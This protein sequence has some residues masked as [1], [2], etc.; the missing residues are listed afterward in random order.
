MKCPSC[1]SNINDND[2]TCKN[3]GLMTPG[4]ELFVN[5]ASFSEWKEELELF[6]PAPVVNDTPNHRLQTGKPTQETIYNLY[7]IKHSRE[8]NTGII[9]GVEVSPEVGAEIIRMVQDGCKMSAIKQLKDSTGI[10]LKE[11]KEAVEAYM[12][13]YR[14]NNSDPN[15]KLGSYNNPIVLP[16]NNKQ[17]E[18]GYQWNISIDGLPVTVD[19][20]PG[21]A[22]FED[23][24][25]ATIDKK[26]YCFVLKKMFSNN[27]SAVSQ[28]PKNTNTPYTQ[29]TTEKPY[30]KP[31]RET[32][33]V[34]KYNLYLFKRNEYV[35]SKCAY[36][37]YDNPIILSC[38]QSQLD[39]G[40]QWTISVDGRSCNVVL[41]PGIANFGDYVFATIR[42]NN[43]FFV[44]EEPV[45]DYKPAKKIYGSNVSYSQKATSRQRTEPA[46]E[47]TKA[48]QQDVRQQPSSNQ[49]AKKRS[50]DLKKSHGIAVASFF[51]PLGVGVLQLLYYL[52]YSVYSEEISDLFFLITIAAFSLYTVEP[53]FLYCGLHNKDARSRGYAVL[54]LIITLLYY[55]WNIRSCFFSS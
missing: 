51:L 5:A 22:L 21:V 17:L 20:A 23:Y 9:G 34:E 30:Q 55:A 28:S 41:D 31:V 24:L 29:S 13:S 35:N 16:C 25:C 15:S 1:N 3:C 43:Y 45:S 46:N 2:F 53:V 40:Y 38:T 12:A 4:A 32:E 6:K 19:L 8:I 49:S 10:G 39:H 11:A 47:K 18:C 14:G 7:P 33:T 27:Q 50:R 48:A 37:S 52:F 44:L 26:D 54:G 36:G 42:K